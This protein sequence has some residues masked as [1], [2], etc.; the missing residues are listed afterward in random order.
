MPVLEDLHS[1]ILRNTPTVSHFGKSDLKRRDEPL[2]PRLPFVR[3]WSMLL[4]IATTAIS[5]EVVVRVYS[6]RLG[7]LEL[8]QIS[9]RV[10]PDSLSSGHISV[11]RNPDIAHVLYCA[12]MGRWG[13]AA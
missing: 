9:R 7:D 8:R 12:G 10:T 11:L 3:V 13:V 5:P 2:Y 4:P 1:F 6:S